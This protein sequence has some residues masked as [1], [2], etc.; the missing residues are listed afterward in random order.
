MRKHR[1]RDTGDD[2]RAYAVDPEWVWSPL[3]RG[4][5]M[6]ASLRVTLEHPD[7]GVA[8]EA[9]RAWL[10]GL[11]ALG[12]DEFGQGGTFIR[13]EGSTVRGL[14]LVL[15]SGGQDALESLDYTVQK[16]FDAVIDP[17]PLMEVV[18][19]EL[20]LHGRRSD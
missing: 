2:P 9:G 19:E 4:L 16:F 11:G 13:I 14:V 1:V 20:A 15:S 12:P 6:T 17:D 8:E 3:N 18:W 10:A 5:T 7:D